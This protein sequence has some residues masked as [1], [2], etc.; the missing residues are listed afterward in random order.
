M[1]NLSDLGLLILRISASALMMVHGYGKLQMLLDGGGKEFPALIGNEP[2]SLILAIIGEFVAPILIII[3]FKTKLSAIPASFTMAVAAFYVHASDPLD[4]KEL[5]LI[6]F[7][8]FLAIAFTG[9]G[10]YSI[11]GIKKK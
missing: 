2:V 6:Y 1:K 10:K 8:I 9:A 7:F 3:G 11:D 5:A 4:K